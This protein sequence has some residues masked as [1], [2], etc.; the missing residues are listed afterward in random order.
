[1][2][3]H[4]AARRD[5]GDDRDRCRDDCQEIKYVCQSCEI[6]GTKAIPDIVPGRHQ[7]EQ[8]S[9]AGN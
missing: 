7:S 3:Q 5:A 1:M 2:D 8:N 4:I 9:F 6:A